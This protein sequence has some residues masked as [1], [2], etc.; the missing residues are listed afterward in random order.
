MKDPMTVT[1]V[2]A[3]R[4]RAAKP[5]DVAAVAAVWTSGW[6]DGHAGHVPAALLAHRT[7]PEFVRRAADRVPHTTVAL[8]PLPDDDVIGFTV[9]RLDE[10][11]QMY[12]SR[13][14]RG[15]GVAQL[16]MAAAEKTIAV[17][18]AVAWLAVVGG[19]ARARRFYESCGWQDVGPFDNPAETA[20]GTMAIPARRYEK[21]LRP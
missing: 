1:R 7:A 3:V 11:E 13:P 14:W 21:R 19:N 18:F 10:V 20:A 4:L 17:R 8:A 12:V 5:S 15:T 2:S 9:V 6:T 16:L